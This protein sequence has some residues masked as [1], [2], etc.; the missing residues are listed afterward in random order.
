[1]VKAHANVISFEKEIGRMAHLDYFGMYVKEISTD[2][3][4]GSRSRM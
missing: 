3:E 4:D 1:M 2:P